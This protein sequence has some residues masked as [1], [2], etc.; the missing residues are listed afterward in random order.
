MENRKGLVTHAALSFSVCVLYGLLLLTP[1]NGYVYTTLLKIA[2]F[3]GCTAYFCKE[4][5]Y[6]CKRLFRNREKQKN[7]GPILCSRCGRNYNYSNGLFSF[8]TFF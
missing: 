2:L 5:A 7:D 1:L 3:F 8:K 4:K 6:E